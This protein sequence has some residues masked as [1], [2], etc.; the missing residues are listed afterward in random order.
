MIFPL[1]YKILEEI[2]ILT[3]K[4]LKNRI[5]KWKRIRHNK[6]TPDET[7]TKESIGRIL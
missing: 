6:H 3:N 4:M 7:K 1:F 5:E 2:S